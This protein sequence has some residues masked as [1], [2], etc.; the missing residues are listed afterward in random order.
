MFCYCYREYRDKTLIIC[1]CWDCQMV[2]KYT[3]NDI[4]NKNPCW[5]CD[6]QYNFIKY[7]KYTNQLSYDSIIEKKVRYSLLQELFSE[8]VE[9]NFDLDCYYDS[10]DDMTRLNSNIKLNAP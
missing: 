8:L 10:D 4:M 3:P 6:S 1:N 5:K 2:N 9:E 7:L